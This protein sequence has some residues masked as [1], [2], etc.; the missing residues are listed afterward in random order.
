MPAFIY[1]VLQGLYALFRRFLF[2]FW[3]RLWAFLL[4]AVPQLLSRVLKWLGFGVVS[5]VGFDFLVDKLFNF[6][7]GRFNGMP[8]ALLAILKIMHVDTGMKLVFTAM[9]IAMAIK[10]ATASSKLIFKP[11]PNNFEV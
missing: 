10:L 11:N 6:L 5:Y 2:I 9:S 1:V 8:S 4:F 3:T 7:M